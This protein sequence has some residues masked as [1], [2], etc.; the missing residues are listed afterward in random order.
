[1][2][3][4]T[5]LTLADFPFHAVA[6]ET[7]GIEIDGIGYEAV[8]VKRVHGNDQ[9][10]VWVAKGVPTPVRILQRENDEDNTDLRLVEYTGRTQ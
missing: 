9:T 3:A 8:K 10:E 7:E 5:S 4:N 2:R 1:M 6:A